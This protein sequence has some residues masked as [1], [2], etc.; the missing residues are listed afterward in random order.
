[1]IYTTVL[2]VG[3]G[4]PIE[5]GVPDTYLNSTFTT[6]NY[7]GD[8]SWVAG[9]STGKVTTARRALVGA[10]LNTAQIPLGAN[11][12]TAQLD[13]YCSS[14]AASAEAMYA[15][16]ATQII[17][18]SG[19]PADGG[20][21][22]NVCTWLAANAFNVWAAGDNPNTP[23]VA[24]NLPTATG[25]MSIT[26]L[27]TIVQDCV[28]WRSGLLSIMLR[29]Q[30]ESGTSA[31]ANFSSSEHATASQRPKLTITWSVE[32]GAQPSFMP[33]LAA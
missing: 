19:D 5:V 1:M 10:N 22:E 18:D 16:R 30:S 3:G 27:E 8:T 31:L 25:A 17:L 4:S 6:T 24:W 26:G 15:S 33:T 2:Q 28:D 9:W 23:N 13:L 14:A 32:E 12:L 7:G 11:I 29:R 21:D 20:W